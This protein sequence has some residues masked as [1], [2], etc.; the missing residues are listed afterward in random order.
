VDDAFERFRR[1]S[2]RTDLRLI[3]AKPKPVGTSADLIDALR[4]PA[5]I[6]QLWMHSGD[7][8]VAL[9]DSR[10]ADMSP[11]DLADLLAGR[12]PRLAILVG[13]SSGAL[14]RALIRCGVLAAVAMR[15]PVFDHTVQPL[16]EDVTATVL[17]GAPVDLA[18]ARALRRYLL[19]GQPGAAAVP[20]LF[21][22]ADA[23][24]VLF[25]PP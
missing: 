11:G 7:E 10:R 2:R 4:T 13:C 8:G 1:R 24:T 15:V 6:L 16:V 20:M 5:D 17:A 19:T 3:H 25:P 23:D 12:P 21:L 18:F 9:T 14:G 22:A